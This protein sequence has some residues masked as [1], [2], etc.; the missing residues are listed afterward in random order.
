MTQFEL[1]LLHQDPTP[2]G[3]SR[4]EERAAPVRSFHFRQAQLAHLQLRNE[5]ERVK[6]EACVSENER[7][8]LHV[9]VLPDKSGCEYQREVRCQQVRGSQPNPTAIGQ[10]K[11]EDSR[12]L[13][14]QQADV[15]GRMPEKPCETAL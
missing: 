3:G 14:I 10:Q 6:G 7:T 1:C 13:A 9:P 4:N 8:D 11:H 15:G 2:H 12:F 5:V